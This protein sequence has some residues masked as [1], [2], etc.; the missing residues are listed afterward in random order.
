M[1]E[2]KR[3]SL[4]LILTIFLAVGMLIF[5]GL[6]VY[7]FRDNEYVRT[8]L[9]TI[10]KK[11][12]TQAREDQKQLSAEENRKANDLPFKT[13][14]AEAVDG[15][16]QLP[17]PKTWSIYYGRNTGGK[18]QVDFAANPEAVTI[19]LNRDGRSTQAFRLQLL[20]ESQSSVVKG[21]DSAI[22]QK[23]VTSK[24]VKVSGIDATQLEG[25]IDDQ[26]HEGVVIIVPVRDKTMLLSTEDKRYLNEFNAIVAG[27]KINP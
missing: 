24:G 20:R 11:E 4:H 21:Y 16:F 7:A 3:I 25:S 19:N 27:A 12:V 8:N 10:V 14:T 2:Q 6:A 13:F 5:G 26:R 23:K 18:T 22:K 1:Y 9:D 15:G 17:I